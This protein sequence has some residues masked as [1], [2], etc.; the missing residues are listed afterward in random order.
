MLNLII[1]G[2]FYIIF[3]LT[4]GFFIRLLV[5]RHAL[6]RLYSYCFA[7]SVN[8]YMLISKKIALAHTWPSILSQVLQTNKW[9]FNDFWEEEIEQ[10][11]NGE[12]KWKVSQ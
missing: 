12:N 3:V 4:L 8:K 10:L 1:N 11:K 7:N 2:L 5:V 6:K 9:T